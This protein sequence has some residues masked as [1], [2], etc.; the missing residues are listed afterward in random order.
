MPVYIQ[1]R[2]RIVEDKENKSNELSSS[3]DSNSGVDVSMPSYSR[4][5]SKGDSDDTN[6]DMPHPVYEMGGGH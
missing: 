3:N 4:Y 1:K 2:C 5:K 6:A